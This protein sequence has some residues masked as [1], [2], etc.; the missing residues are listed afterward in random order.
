M[1][2]TRFT[3][4]AVLGAAAA[5]AL[6]ACAANEGGSGDAANGSEDGTA[7]EGTINASGA[8]SQVAAQEAWV[9]GF[10]PQTTA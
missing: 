3:S 6:T 9:A 10:R 7:L 2:I 8:S 4:V 5:L 1:K